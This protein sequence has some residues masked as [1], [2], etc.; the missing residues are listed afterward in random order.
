[1]LPTCL[2]LFF[3]LPTLNIPTVCRPEW[4][5]KEEWSHL[6]TIWIFFFYIT[7]RCESSEHAYHTS[8][9]A[10][11]SCPAH[12]APACRWGLDSASCPAASPSCWLSQPAARAAAPP[13]DVID[14]RPNPWWSPQ[15]CRPT[16]DIKIIMS[17]KLLFIPP[18]NF[19]YLPSLCSF[20]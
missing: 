13:A 7:H 9:G 4:E 12:V 5:K 16:Q 1:M 15:T 6:Y 11:S 18:P 8:Q 10:G 2:T 19:I 3:E 17:V 20:S 14:C